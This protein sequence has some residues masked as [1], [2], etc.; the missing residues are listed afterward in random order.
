M[1]ITAFFPVWTAAKNG[2]FTSR[3]THAL[4]RAA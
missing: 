4:F 2:Q 3:F 1:E